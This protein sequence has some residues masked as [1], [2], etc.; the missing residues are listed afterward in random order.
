R[1]LA[2]GHRLV[3][4]GNG[5]VVERPQ[6]QTRRRCLCQYVIEPQSGIEHGEP[7]IQRRQNL[8]EVA[9][10][11]LDM[12]GAD[13]ATIS[14]H[15]EIADQVLD[16]VAGEQ[17]D[18]VVAADAALG[19]KRRN[20]PGQP[21]QLSVAD[22]AS[23]VDRNNIG[24]VRIALGG[25]IDPVSKQVWPKLSVFRHGTSTVWEKRT[26]GAPNGARAYQ[27]VSASGPK[28]RVDP[29]DHARLGVLDVLLGEEILRLDPVDRIDRP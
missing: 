28:Q 19:Q 15:A 20:L 2:S 16:R 11:H 9:A 22:R 26:P 24:L 6:R 12:D 3:K 4:A 27:W 17:G 7:R 29:A 23:I 25:A 21:P 14:H 8:R 13:G 1:R 18:A 10:V 5:I